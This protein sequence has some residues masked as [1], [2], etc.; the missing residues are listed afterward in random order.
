VVLRDSEK[1]VVG[2][3]ARTVVG[4]LAR[5][6]ILNTVTLYNLNTMTR[7]TQADVMPREVHDIEA[8]TFG[9]TDGEKNE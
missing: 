5:T 8:I 4:N 1:T 2:N 3:L 7:K 9:N 6:V